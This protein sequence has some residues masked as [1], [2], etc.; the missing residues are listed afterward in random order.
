MPTDETVHTVLA[1]L[2]LRVV[3]DLY[4]DTWGHVATFLVPI[5]IAA[6]SNARK[7]H[8]AHLR[9]VLSRVICARLA[10]LV[11]PQLG[12]HWPAGV[13]LSGSACWHVLD[14]DARWKPND[15][16]VFCFFE[17]RQAAQLWLEQCG[18][19]PQTCGHATGVDYPTQNLHAIVNFYAWRPDH[20]RIPVDADCASRFTDVGLDMRGRV[21][22]AGADAT[23][24]Q[25]SVVQLIILKAGFDLNFDLPILLNTYNGTT[26]VVQRPDLVAAR[27]CD[28]DVPAHCPNKKYGTC[29]LH[30]AAR[31]RAVERYTKYA[32]RGIDIAVHALPCE[33]CTEE[34]KKGSKRKIGAQ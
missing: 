10:T 25:R 19:Y 2:V 7:R 24:G 8:R 17:Q 18:L 26:F 6:L 34:R 21:W 1:Y 23:A 22:P 30:N 20:T 5:D 3:M 16:D 29:A 33:T 12:Y 13:H 14:G 9:R 4:D 27:V 15:L 11:P 28:M 31:Q 32:A